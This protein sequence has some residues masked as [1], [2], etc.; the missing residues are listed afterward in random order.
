MSNLSDWGQAVADAVGKMIEDRRCH[1]LATYRLQ[2]AKD[3]LTF[4]NAAAIV[5]YLDELGISHVYASPYLKTQSGSAHGYA[6]VDYGQLNPELGDEADYRA[7]VDALYSRKMGQ[8]IDIVPNHMSAA[9]LENHWWTDVLENG[10]GSPFASYFDIDWNPI[11][12]QLHNKILLPVLG[13]QYGQVLESGELNVEYSEG[14]FFIRYYQMLLPL[15]PRTY[16]AILTHRIDELKTALPADSE[17]LPELKSI[18]T[19]LEHLPERTETDTDRITERQREKVVIKGRL[20][21]LV[22]RSLEIADFIRQN[23]HFFNGNPEDPH[24]FNELDKLLDAQVYRL[25]H[26]KAAADEINYRRF[27]DI[28]EL[29]AVCMEDPKVFQESHQLA[30]DLLVCGDVAGLRID[31]IDGLYDPMEYLRRLQW[32]YLRALGKTAYRKMAEKPAPAQPITAGQASSGTHATDTGEP[33]HWNDVETAFLQN[34]LA[35]LDRAS[36]LPASTFSTLSSGEGQG[37]RDIPLYVVVEKILGPEEPLPQQWLVAG[38]TGYD[39][40]NAMNGLFVDRSGLQEL[41]KL[42]GRFIDQRPSY[43]EIAHQSK[44]LILRTAMSSDLQLLAHQINRIS[45]RHRR[46]RDF[47]LNTLRIALR[48]ILTCFPVYRTYIRE[49]D[50]SER[51]RQFVVRAAAQ[52]KRRNPAM[53]SAVFDFIRDVL[54]L[55]SPPGLD[56]AGR[57]ERA[58][59]VGRFQQVT[60]PVMAKGIED[61]AFYRYFPLASLNEVGGDPARGVTTIEVFHAQ[62]IARQMQWPRSLTATTSHDTKR[63]EDMRARLNVLSEIPHLWRKAVN[64]WARLNRRHLREVNG[65]PAPSRNDEYHFYQSLTGIWPLA[66]PEGKALGEL[67]GRIQSYM[68]KATREAKLQTSWVNPVAEY[69]AAVHDFVAA[70]LDGRKKNRFL[71]EF[72]RFHKQIVNWGLFSALSQTL[73]KLT[74]PGVPDIYQGQELWEFS[75]VDPDNRRPVDFAH[76]KEMLAKLRDNLSVDDGSLLALARRLVENPRD[77]QLKLFVTWRILQLR[78]QNVDLF[79]KG[80]YIPLEVQGSRAIH[81]CAF[82]REYQ[83][84]QDSNKQIVIIIAPRLIA[85][86]TPLPENALQP[87]PPLG[88]AIWEDTRIMLGDLVS[89]PLKNL[90]TGQVCPAQDSQVLLATAFSDFPVALLTDEP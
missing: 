43:E 18:V 51:D 80:K 31:H 38:T 50:V 82:A 90:F 67:T 34:T 52:A 74:S 19:A 44:L 85:Q 78:R 20:R 17:D 76:R 45:E 42:Y 36:T 48:E 46:S 73:L 68:E 13:D 41:V 53:D 75:L 56:E 61:T 8:I 86:L 65:Q 28:N 58:L 47:T 64:R 25:S 15:D 1:P 33:P 83:P 72:R 71:A 63:S 23:V 3:R 11:K 57:H 54:L 26:W 27:F 5:P 77:C 6:I 70:A 22:E 79:Q 10:P 30:L 39:F 59:F 81:V 12:E 32:G 66:E 40:L 55:E 37:V 21:R 49:G 87:P 14:A 16:R 89:S 29:A 24:T 9:P 60:S 88:P 4:R 62:N 84:V 35:S 7:L 2:F 69:D